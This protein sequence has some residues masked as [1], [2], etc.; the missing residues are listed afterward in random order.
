MDREQGNFYAD[1]EFEPQEDVRVDMSN[2]DQTEIDDMSYFRELLEYLRKVITTS[3]SVP[4]SNK[5]LVDSDICMRIIDNMERNLPDAVQYGLQVYSE[6]GRILDTA[7]QKAA[8]MMSSAEMRA[9]A[10]LDKAKDEAEQQLSDAMSE[11]DAIV[12]DAKERAARLVSDSVIMEEAREEA[13]IT[14]NEARV[15]A[16]ETRLQAIHEAK[17]LL[18]DVE[19]E[20]A[21][22]L[23]TIRRRRG[24]LESKEDEHF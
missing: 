19:T 24:E 21:E 23:A 16:N 5:K 8:N 11:A 2:N 13:R 17:L 4:L 15:E 14:K 18:N 1:E 10:A 3:R 22:A 6:Q 7:E 20:L 9:T 12:S